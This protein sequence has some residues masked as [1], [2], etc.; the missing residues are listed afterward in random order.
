MMTPRAAR[1]ALF[2][3]ALMTA[4]AP[5][6]VPV[7]AQAAPARPSE[8]NAFARRV[9]NLFPRASG[10]ITS[11]R[12]LGCSWT[13]VDGKALTEGET[14]TLTA[15]RNA[16]PDEMAAYLKYMD[17]YMD[18]MAKYG[19]ASITPIAS[20]GKGADGGRPASAAVGRKA[21]ITVSPALRMVTGYMLCGSHFI[22]ADMNMKPDSGVD[23][24]RLFD[25][26]VPQ[27]LPLIGK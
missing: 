6:L 15:H 14:L 24:A 4:L 27:V 21:I 20:C 7:A 5:A 13:Q 10:S 16:T 23:P 12:G 17:G 8:A 22:S 18:S 9:C 1:A 26:L 3:C 2:A 19:V 11:W 25:D